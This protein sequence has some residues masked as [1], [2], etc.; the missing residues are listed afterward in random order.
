L[1]EVFI[2]SNVTALASFTPFAGL[3]VA[4]STSGLAGASDE[5]TRD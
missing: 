2:T 3:G 1:G 4:M 5:G